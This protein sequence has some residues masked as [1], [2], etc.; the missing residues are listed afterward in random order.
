MLSCSL[1]RISRALISVADKT[2]IVPLARTLS[3]LGIEIITTGG[4]AALLHS[5]SIPHRLVSDLTRSPEI[6]GGRVKTLHPIIHGGILARRAIDQ[7]EMQENNIHGIDL[8][9]VNLY[10]F[11]KVIA[12][13]NCDWNTAIENI[14]IGGPT[15]LRAAAK[16][17]D[18]VSVIVD[19]ADYA[20]LIEELKKN[21]RS[22]SKTQRLQW[23]LKAFSH[24]ANYDAMIARYFEMN[25]HAPTHSE[26]TN[27]GT[28]H[29]P[30]A[31]NNQDEFFNDQF[32]LTLK[33][34]M[35]LRYGENPHQRAAFY[36]YPDAPENSLAN[37]ELKQGKEL[38]YNNIA[39]ADAA[40][41]C[42][43]AFKNTHACVIVK[44][45][46]PCGIAVREKQVDAYLRAHATDPQSA[47]GGI[48]AFNR[49]IEIE[50]AH[51]IIKNQFAEVI[52]AP[53]IFPDALPIFS[54][55][56]NLRILITGKH[57]INATINTPIN[58]PTITNELIHSEAKPTHW[59]IKPVS[60]GC[61]IQE[62][63]TVDLIEENLRCVTTRHPTANELADLRFAWTA[64]KHVKSN[65]IVFASDCATIGIGAGQMSRV[66]S[67]YIAKEK[68]RQANLST[69]GSVMASDAFFPFADAIDMAAESGVTAIIQPGG[70]INDQS[71]IDAANAANIAMLFTH[72]RHFQ[73]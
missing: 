52:I 26:N 47:F 34:K 69:K 62:P 63:D 44:H 41:L 36:V 23:A 51:T 17:H 54:E 39:D 9:I 11:S 7:T 8:V 46:N 31:S 43:N 21:N 57:R 50:T 42:V 58:T 35:E 22:T 72:I 60:G 40:L 5:H 56:P 45:A 55:K 53:D 16:N 28:T 6:F 15:M 68:A 4:T 33:K 12:E 67:T 59:F 65:A 14:D 37:A 24:T 49:P 38:S 70:S 19:V 64:V 20:S 73:H 29:T 71:V 2:D 48:I 27:N 18:D 30:S 1:T 66:N 25:V 32:Q 61:L 10:P 13:P 3:E